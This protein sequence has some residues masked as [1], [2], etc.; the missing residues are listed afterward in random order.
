MANQGHA[1]R[2]LVDAAKNW[3]AIDGLWF[4]AVEA[5]FGMEAAISCDKEVWERFSAIEARRIKE[6]LQLPDNGRLDALEQALRQ[7]LFSFVNEQRVTRV[8]PRTLEYY[9]VTCR[10]QQARDR[11][12]LPKFPCRELGEVEHRSFARVIDPRIRVECISCPPDP[13]VPGFYCGWRFVIPP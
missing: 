8:D 1:G 5:R 11:K 13:P 3:H 12:G 7:R 9:L 6:R 10:T 4:I 2:E